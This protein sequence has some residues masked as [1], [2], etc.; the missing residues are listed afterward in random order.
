MYFQFLFNSNFV[1]CR[2]AFFYSI[3][4]VLWESSFSFIGN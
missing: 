1:M 4:F 2:T 3:F